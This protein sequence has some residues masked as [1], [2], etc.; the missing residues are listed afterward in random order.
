MRYQNYLTTA[1]LIAVKA[2]KKSQ[3]T[4]PVIHPIPVR[5]P[6]MS[7]LRVVE[8]GSIVGTD[9]KVLTIID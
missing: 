9:A 1:V 6:Q 2:R 7:R 8:N 4:I 5:K 3:V